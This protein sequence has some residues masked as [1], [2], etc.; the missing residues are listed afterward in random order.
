MISTRLRC[1]KLY[2]PIFHG[3]ISASKYDEDINTIDTSTPTQVQVTG[4]VTRARARQLNYQVRSLLGLCPTYLDH[5]NT[6]TLVL[7]RNDGEDPKGKGFTQA[8][9]GRGTALGMCFA[10][11]FS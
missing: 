4:P 5:G 3:T 2:V 10:S 9:F 6:C 11:F 1:P 7:L 8:G